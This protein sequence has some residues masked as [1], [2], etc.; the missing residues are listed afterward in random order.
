M[1]ALQH[2]SV[3]AMGDCSMIAPEYAVHPVGYVH[4]Q[5]QCRKDA[6]RQGSE[7]APDAWLEIDLRFLDGLQGIAPGDEVILVTWLHKAQRDTLLVHP[8]RD[9]SRP[10]VGVFATRS[11]D[12]PNPLGLHA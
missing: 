8:R 9:S 4:S 10:L 2:F 6:P 3:F 12:R 5:L 1:S 11:P 7:G